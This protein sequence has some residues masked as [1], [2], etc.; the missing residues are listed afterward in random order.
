M[1][2]CLKLFLSCGLFLLV[3]PYF[4]APFLGLVFLSSLF[5]HA[6]LQYTNVPTAL[7]VSAVLIWMGGHYMWELWERYYPNSWLEKLYRWADF[8]DDRFKY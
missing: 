1:K 4:L 5:D 8:E 7:I 2:W 6:P 3:I